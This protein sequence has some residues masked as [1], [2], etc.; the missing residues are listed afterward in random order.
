MAQA[1]APAAAVALPVPE[2]SSLT[3]AVTLCLALGPAAPSPF[4]DP[5]ASI[6]P[7]TNYCAQLRHKAWRCKNLCLGA[8]II[9]YLG[10]HKYA[11]AGFKVQ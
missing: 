8:R 11:L 1:V 2:V 10:A 9:M 5:H 4:L 6:P 7:L 3:I